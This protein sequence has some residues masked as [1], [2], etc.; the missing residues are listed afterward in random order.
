MKMKLKLYCH[1][2]L[3]SIFN[4]T[5]SMRTAMKSRKICY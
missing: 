2:I 4:I 3:L 1:V 5:S